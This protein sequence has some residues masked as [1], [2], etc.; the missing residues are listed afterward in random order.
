MD[1]HFKGNVGTAALQRAAN[2]NSAAVRRY[3]LDV[4]PAPAAALGAPWLAGAGIGQARYPTAPKAA[5]LTFHAYSTI[6]RAADAWETLQRDA[7]TFPFQTFEWLCAWHRDIGAPRGIDPL[8]VAGRDEAGEVKILFPLGIERGWL[9]ARL[10]WLGHPICDYNAP[11]VCPKTLAG[12]SV[13]DAEAIWHAILSLAPSLDYAYLTRQPAM[14]GEAE[15]PFHHVASHPFSAGAHAATLDASW[16]EFYRGRRSGRARNKNARMEKRLAAL[17]EL[18][19]D[20]VDDPAER[21]ELVAWVLDLK[22][23]Q[24]TKTGARSPFGANDVRRF[25]DRVSANDDFKLFRL[26]LDSEP[27]AAVLG[28]VR[29]GCFYYLVP[30]YEFGAHARCSPGSTLLHKVME[31]CIDQGLTR[32]D[33]TIGDEAYKRDWS[34]IGVPMSFTCLP[35]SLKGWFAMAVVTRAMAAK[36][37]L[38]R[39]AFALKAASWVISLMQRQR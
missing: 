26:T 24:L 10:V 11:L 27:L 19:F 36:R 33:F 4:A 32:F 37:L 16:D 18:R 21:S 1:A 8:I 28:L 14:I 25:F 29:N 23:R 22:H 3:R 35:V 31:W 15:N 20:S 30:V 5:G 9:T 2:D 7:L 13:Q 6:H 39:H 34:D 17:G 12:L 38:K